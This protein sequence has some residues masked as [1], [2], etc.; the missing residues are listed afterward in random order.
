MCTPRDTAVFADEA[1]KLDDVSWFMSPARIVDIAKRTQAPTYTQATVS[2]ARVLRSPP[3][4]PPPNLDDQM[5]TRTL[6]CAHLLSCDLTVAQNVPVTPST[7]V[8]SAAH[9]WAFV[10]DGTR[11]PAMI[12]ALDGGGGRRMRFISAEEGVEKVFK[13]LAR[14]NMS[15]P[16]ATHP[17]LY[18]LR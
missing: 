18:A 14:I 4:S 8:K 12:K 7:R 15:H 3:C 16:L 2:L 10:K 6:H 13:Q 1:V 9:V 11:Y 17:T 5:A